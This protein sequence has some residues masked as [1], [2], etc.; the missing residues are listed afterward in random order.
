MKRILGLFAVFG[1]L[2]ILQGCAVYPYPYGPPAP[3]TG[4]SPAY[5]Y[6][7]SYQPYVYR[8]FPGYYGYRPYR[9]FG[10]GG[11]YGL[12]FGWGGRH[13]WSGRGPGWGGRHGWSGGFGRHHR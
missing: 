7:F 1:S 8:P 4:Y 3:Y 5:S 13:G 12:N 2:L 9:N 6:N 10:W 11:G